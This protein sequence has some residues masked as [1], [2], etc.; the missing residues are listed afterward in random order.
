VTSSGQSNAPDSQPIISVH[1]FYQQAGGEDEVFRAETRLLVARGHHVVQYT[2]NNETIGTAAG[3]RTARNTLWNPQPYRELRALFR[4]HRPRVAH[5][6]NTFP[7][8][9]PA[10]YHAAR[11]ERVPVVQTLH[12]FRITCPNALFFRQ[13]RVCEDCLGK[14]VPWPGILHACYRGSAAAS[15]VTAAMLALH[16]VMGTWS[17]AVDVYIALSQFARD[18]FIAA[19]IAAERIVVKPNFLYPDPGPGEHTGSFALFVGRLS[20]EK[21]VTTLLDAWREI[22]SGFTLKVVGAGPEESLLAQPR[23]GVEWLGWQPRERVVQLMKEAAFLV[24]PSEWY[25]NFPM[26]LVEAYAT[27]LPVIGS[28]LGSLAELIHD[29][30]TG[31]HFRPGDAT[32]LAGIIEWAVRHPALLAEQGRNARREFDLRYTA[33]Q[34]YAA[35]MQIYRVAGAHAQEYA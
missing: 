32:E 30:E 17:R 21:G 8:I 28:A 29:G 2:A 11:A 6:H 9:S 3:L 7:L 14:L 12:N 5:F 33:D 31:R 27:G 23:P 25:E 13:G 15:G 34:N 26:T 1:N 18:K 16:R 19:G 10:A 24:L 22:G 4:Q 20:P 35:L